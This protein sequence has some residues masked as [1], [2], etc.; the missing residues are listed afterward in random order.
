MRAWTVYIGH[1]MRK[2]ANGT[3][4]QADS[5]VCSR[6]IQVLREKV[7]GRFFSK[8]LHFLCNVNMLEK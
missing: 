2:R 5:T 3:T 8:V 7:Y 4:L 6:N 1:V